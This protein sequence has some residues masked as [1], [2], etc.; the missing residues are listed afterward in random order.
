VRQGG[1]H[2]GGQTAVRRPTGALLDRGVAVARRWEVRWKGSSVG[3][4][5]VALAQ[6]NDDALDL[7]RCRK[8]LARI[9]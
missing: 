6:E 4:S 7:R 9:R 2:G 1:S 5:T 8:V 3:T